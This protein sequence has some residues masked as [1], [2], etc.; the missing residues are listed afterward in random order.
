M[1]MKVSN[2]DLTEHMSKFEHKELLDF[3]MKDIYVTRGLN[4][5]YAKQIDEYKK[6]KIGLYNHESRT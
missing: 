3:T 1:N 5:I 6:K 4:K 2:F